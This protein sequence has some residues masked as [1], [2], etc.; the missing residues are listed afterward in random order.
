M[1]RVATGTLTYPAP[2]NIDWREGTVECW[3][4]FNFE[5]AASLPSK[6]YQGFAALLSLSGS[7]GAL[8][9]HYMAQPG[10]NEAS[11]WCSIGPETVFTAF[12]IASPPVHK[13][14]WHHIALVWAGESTR[15]Y[16]DGKLA[17][18][19]THLVTLAKGFGA[20]GKEIFV[21][22]K[23][24]ARAHYVLDEF[25][26]S[27]VARRPEELGFNGQLKRDAFTSILDPFEGDFE[28]DGKAVT[29]PSVMLS[30]E[31][32]VPSAQCQF[33]DGKFG[34]GLAFYREK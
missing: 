28:P 9:I 31:G 2:D 19:F 12:G 17:G 21:G 3:I 8:N 1:P 14:E 24:N 22:D 13:N 15:A 23:W 27:R 26:V 10:S 6:D 33:V 29:H 7:A 18:H 16:F 4:K 25:R 32:G 5:P 34:K 20:V 30:G 11:W